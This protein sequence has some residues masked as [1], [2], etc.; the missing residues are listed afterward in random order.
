VALTACWD[1]ARDREVTRLE[2]RKMYAEE[3]KITMQY[4]R[5]F[6]DKEDSH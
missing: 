1:D 4:E 5:L 6:S 3:Y 2:E